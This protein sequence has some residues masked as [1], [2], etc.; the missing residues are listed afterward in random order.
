MSNLIKT[1]AYITLDQAKIV[2]NLEHLL[3]RNQPILKGS[4]HNEDALLQQ[5]SE[6]QRLHSLR[7][8]ILQDAEEFAEG[9]IRQSQ[10]EADGMKAAAEAE[11]ATWWNKQRQADEE[12]TTRAREDGYQ[13]GYKEGA[14]KADE[15]VRSEYTA[16]IVEAS[17]VLE[18][19][20]LV[21]EE[22][23]R[24]AEPFLIEIST[25]IAEKIISHQLSIEPD[26]IVQIARGILARKREKGLVTLCVAPKHFA[27]FQDARNELQLVIDS[28]AELQILPDAS[29]TDHGCV[30]RT[31]FGSVDARIDTQLKEIKQALQSLVMNND[32]NEST[33]E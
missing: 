6:L 11:I 20:Y 32:Q 14:V 30:M 33:D 8:Q 9:H 19:A 23:I 15:D 16:M 4:D 21:K 12:E 29:V 13:I 18:H 2:D 10:K 25:G 31:E 24:E 28:Q 3:K 7:D 26:W 22:I 5:A 1:D 27:Y 17:T